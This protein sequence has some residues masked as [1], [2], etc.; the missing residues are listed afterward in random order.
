MKPFQLELLHGLENVYNTMSD[1]W[2]AC[3]MVGQCAKY[4]FTGTGHQVWCTTKKWQ[5]EADIG[6]PHQTML[7]VTTL[8]AFLAGVA[9]GGHGACP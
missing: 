3:A 5:I 8:G 4:I 2:Y 9:C 6:M 7:G 1:N